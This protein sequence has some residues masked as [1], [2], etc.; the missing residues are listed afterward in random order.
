MAAG[1]LPASPNPSIALQKPNPVTD[2]ASA[3][4]PA[5]TDHHRIA[6]P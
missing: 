1:K 6:V 5:A 3:C 4:R 2:P